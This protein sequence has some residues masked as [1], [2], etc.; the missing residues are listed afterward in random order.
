MSTSVC[1]HERDM[2][3]WGKP[4]QMP[5]SGLFSV[6]L[7]KRMPSIA[8]ISFFEVPTK[9]YILT[10]LQR[11]TWSCDSEPVCVTVTSQDNS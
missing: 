8:N 6:C 4:E 3:D 1:E 2:Q 11:Y 7:V 10:M 9:V 5:K